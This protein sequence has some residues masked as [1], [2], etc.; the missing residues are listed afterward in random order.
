M[1][2]GA[3]RDTAPS[4]S[5][6]KGKAICVIRRIARLAEA[7]YAQRWAGFRHPSNPDDE[8][9]AKRSEGFTTE[10][11]EVTEAV[12]ASGLVESTESVL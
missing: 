9:H 8:P 5:Q 11:T 6:F 12:Q 1:D 7:P 3:G 4:D 2:G 10:I